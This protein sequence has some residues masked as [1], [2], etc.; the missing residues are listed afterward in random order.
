MSFLAAGRLWLVL[1]PVALAIG[2]LIAQ[3]RHNRHAVRFTNLEL[4]DKVAPERP[5]WRR[6]LP[7]GLLV[8]A[9][10]VL[11]IAAARPVTT[12]LVP[13]ERA[14]VVLAIDTSISMEAVDV[15]PNRL[16]AA[17]H[18][19]LDFV[20]EVPEE[21]RIGV[22]A[23]SGSVTVLSNPTDDRAETRRAIESMELSEGTAIGE[24]IFAA[25]RLIATDAE[26]LD[27]EE[28]DGGEPPAA[29]I[30]VLSD[31][32]TVVGR[33]NELAAEAAVEQT[34]PVSTIGF[35]T[36]TGTVTYQGETIPV[37]VNEEALQA[38]ADTT[39]GR[40]FDADSAE[41]LN[42]VFDTLGTQVGRVEE[43]REVTDRFGIAAL[44]LATLAAAAGIAWFAR[45]P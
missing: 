37:P 27:A 9:L 2:Y 43:E 21:V 38:V 6:H 18:A 35:G 33:P 15:E 41:D 13:S 16:E 28:L 19:A 5:G 39:G 30:L 25:L 45:I 12:V 23:F 31:G 44:V 26:E 17:R 4:L 11:S 14:T 29:T 32:E 1:L 22:I 34:I 7:A 8:A 42:Q 10:A 24:A 40:F 3:R 20:D 36:D